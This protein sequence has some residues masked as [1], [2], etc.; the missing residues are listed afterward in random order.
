MA[1]GAPVG[2][3]NATQGRPWRDAINRALA[4]RD[5]REQGRAL[6]NLAEKLLAAAEIGDVSALRELGDR[7]E[8]KPAQAVQLVGD[9]D[10]PV[11]AKMTVEF[12]SATAAISGAQAERVDSTDPDS[13]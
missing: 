10:N 7:L 2:N 12:V 9:A 11:Q 13:I 1:G 4:K 6:A 5:E 3:K 8:G